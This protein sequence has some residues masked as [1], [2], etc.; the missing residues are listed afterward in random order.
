[1]GTNIGDIIRAD[2][3]SL[4][5]LS[6]RRIAIDAF[7][8]LY[9]FLSIIRQPDGTPLKDRQGRITSHLSGLF[10]RNVRLLE[11][12][13]LPAYV[14]DGEA[15]SLK[16]EEVERRREIRTDAEKEWK[17]AK[18]EG[19][20]EDARKAAQASSRLTTNMIEGS[21][22]LL[23]ALG[24]PVIQAPSEG[25]ALA[26]QIA[27]NNMVW[28]SASQDYDSLLYD[29]PL[30]V[31]NLS[32][33]GRRR[34]AR[35]K[36]YK[37][38]HPEIIDLDMNLKLLEV[39]RPQLIDI[40]IMVGTDYNDNIPGVGAKTALKL[41]QEYGD[42][43]TAVETK[44]LEVDFPYERIREIFLHPP[45]SHIEKLEWTDPDP[46]AVRGLL[47]DV[48]DFS[49]NRVNS[50]LGRLEKALREIEESGQQSSLADFL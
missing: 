24:I 45:E 17:K 36:R 1:M 12:G 28:A 31:R 43:E 32:I 26:A 37:T 29:C 50:T 34:V 5:A 35:S 11:H 47:C 21:K 8:T 2:E 15:P 7:N 14:Y 42:L 9:Q 33:T 30:M 46:D 22:S 6:G 10:Y 23:R 41:I 13:I 25:E 49:R 19:R 48:H 40:A 39:T 27:R 16:S 44:D 4:E 18:A 38:V 20:I 3:S